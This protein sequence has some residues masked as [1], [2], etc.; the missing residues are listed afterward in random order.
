MSCSH[1]TKQD[2]EELKKYS[3]DFPKS[4]FLVPHKQ[5]QLIRLPRGGIIIQTSIG[6]IQFGMP[7]E[8]VKDSMIMGIDIP[9]IYVLPPKRFDFNMCLNVAEFEF[10]VYFNFFVRKKQVILVCTQEAKEAILTVFQETL[11]GPVSFDVKKY[12]YYH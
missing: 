1:I 4:S 10:P 5:E 2:F 11:L 6:N 12:I 9:E 3:Q 7:P 8:T